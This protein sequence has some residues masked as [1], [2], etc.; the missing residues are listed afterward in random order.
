MRETDH[1]GLFSYLINF[2]SR[3]SLSAFLQNDYVQLLFPFDPTNSRKDSLKIGSKHHWNTVGAS[4]VSKPQSLFTYNSTIRYGGYYANGDKLSI[5][6]DVGYRFQPYLNLALSSTF[7]HLSLP[8]PWG[9]T[10]FWL[11]GPKVDLTMT[12]KLFFTTYVQYNQQ[13][14][15][16]N[17]NA[18]FQWRYKPASDLFIVYTDN[19]LTVPFS[20]RNRAL[21]L[22]YTY[23]WN[24]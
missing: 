5:S 18:R 24:L 3:S 7:N 19:Y 23:W 11:V 1:I 15:N 21:L 10:N 4:F 14:K 8:A 22:K 16:T 13:L 9:N 17:I 2:R 20:V 12:N 6:A